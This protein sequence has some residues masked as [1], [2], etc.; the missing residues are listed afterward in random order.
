MFVRG[1]ITALGCRFDF[2][3]FLACFVRVS[4]FAFPDFTKP[5]MPTMLCIASMHMPTFAWCEP[6]ILL[7]KYFHHSIDI[8]LNPL[9]PINASETQECILQARGIGFECQKAEGYSLPVMLE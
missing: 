7:P 9:P 8:K 5:M 6:E 1:K 3:V 2:Q 4:S